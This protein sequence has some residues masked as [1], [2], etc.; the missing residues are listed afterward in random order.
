[1]EDISDDISTV[2]K[3]SSLVTSYNI[4]NILFKFFL[5]I[6]IATLHISS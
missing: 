6:N 4:K 3:I 2:V 1:M 5:S